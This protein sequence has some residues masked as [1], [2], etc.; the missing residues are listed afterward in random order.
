MTKTALELKQKAAGY[1]LAAKNAEK[2]E[3][4]NNAQTTKT[5]TKTTTKTTTTKIVTTTTKTTVKK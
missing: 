3:Q 5:K 2:R 4:T 1:M